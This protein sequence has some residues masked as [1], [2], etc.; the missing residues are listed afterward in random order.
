MNM[1]RQ[2]LETLELVPFRKVI[3]AGIGS[4]MTAH[5][6]VPALEPDPNIPATLSSRV[7]TDLLQRQLGFSKLVVTDSLTMAGL[8]NGFWMGDAAVRAIK[9]GVDV[10]LDPP[11]PDVV[12]QAVLEAAE[13]GE[14]S[15]ERIDHSVRKI[16][17]AKAW[18]GLHETPRG[19]APHQRSGGRSGSARAGATDG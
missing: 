11:N 7:L 19:S 14:I 6:S 4:I 9:A 1:D 15:S 12:C 13:R 3:D 17:D 10:L 5:V 2:R 8:A 18:L 16:L